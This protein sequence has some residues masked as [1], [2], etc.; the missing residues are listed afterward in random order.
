[1]NIKHINSIYCIASFYQ[2]VEINDL[3]KLQADLKKT[4]LY[5]KL[6]GTILIASE[7][8]NGTVSGEKE[9][10]TLFFKQ[11]ESDLRFKNIEI[12]YSYDNKAAFHRMKIRLK[13]EVIK[14]GKDK[15]N[16]NPIK[17]VG[18]YVNAKDW[19]NIINDPEILLID[20]RNFYETS[21]G[22]FKGAIIPETKSF[23]E[24]PSWFEKNINL[25]NKNN[26]KKNIAMF[27]T[28]G[29]RCEKATSFVLGK[30]YKSI[31][32]LKGGILK[33]LEEV[34]ENES[35]WNGE[36]FVFDDRVSVQHSLL[37]G[38][39]SMCHACRMPITEKDKNNKSYVQGVSCYH[40]VDEKSEEK[41]RRYAD[42]QKQ[43]ELAAKRGEIHI[44]KK[45]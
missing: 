4:C 45:F 36:C 7:G 21:V 26:E 39:Y 11:L 27:C 32:H 20:I 43:V 15:N 28:G 37:P 42:R 6:L 40:C 30:G 8:I 23:S 34:P 14:M 19:N 1:M 17:K 3:P 13:E 35:L 9:N 16:V 10:I 25:L 12:K 41:K 24:F 22:T 5:Y 44:G 29:I 31:F 33:Y 38:S 2:F 18:K